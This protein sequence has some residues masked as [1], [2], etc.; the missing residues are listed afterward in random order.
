MNTGGGDGSHLK[1]EEEYLLEK[2]TYEDF[3]RLK[4]DFKRLKGDLKRL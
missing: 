2:R 3:K 1:V 4:G